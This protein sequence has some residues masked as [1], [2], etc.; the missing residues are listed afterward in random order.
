MFLNRCR[1]P[2]GYEHPLYT[3]AVGQDRGG[4]IDVRWAELVAQ[5]S[6]AG[7]YPKKDLTEHACSCAT[8]QSVRPSCK[9]TRVGVGGRMLVELLPSHLPFASPR[10]TPR[11]HDINNVRDLRSPV[12]RDTASSTQDTASPPSHACIRG[13]LDSVLYFC[14]ARSR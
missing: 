7:L 6:R 1:T 2:T 11:H 5:G 10:T 12:H 13:V 9:Q 14:N 4:S 8:C 3:P